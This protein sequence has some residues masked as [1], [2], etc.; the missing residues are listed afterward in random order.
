MSQVIPQQ[1]KFEG[2]SYEA[3]DFLATLKF[4]NTPEHLP[5][6]K[7]LYQSLITAPL[8][9][10][11]HALTPAALSV[12]D[13][14]ITKPSR[15]I[16]TMYTDMRFSRNTPL[17]E[18]MYIRFREPGSENVLGLYFDMGSCY[19]SYGIRIYKQNSAGMEHIR[20]CVLANRK[21]YTEALSGLGHMGMTIHGDTFAKDRYPGEPEVLKELLNRRN[22]YIG[23][24]CEI[25][26]AVFNGDMQCEIAEAYEGLKP[27][28]ALLHPHHQIP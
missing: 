6:N 12:S 10:L 8:T 26:A 18:Y 13:T 21:A 7:P 11:Y 4:R 5:E 28:Y 22:F 1:G 20:E 24:E 14:L 16:S 19:Y 2:F 25:G 15:C 23:R 27:M 3:I 17:K 9:Q